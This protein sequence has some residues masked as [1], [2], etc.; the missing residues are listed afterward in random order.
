ME[1]RGDLQGIV[2][3]ATTFSA[4]ANINVV[5]DSGIVVLRGSVGTSNDK[6]LVENMLRLQ[7][8]VRDVRNELDVKQP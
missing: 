3:R 4:P 6:R 1:R 5:M 2:T 8:G 7:P